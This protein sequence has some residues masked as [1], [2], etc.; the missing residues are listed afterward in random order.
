MNIHRPGAPAAE[1]RD[2]PADDRDQAVGEVDGPLAAVLGCADLDAAAGLALDLAVNDEPA[3]VEIEVPDLD[4]GDLADPEP[5]RAAS[6]TNVW[7]SLSAESRRRLRRG[8]AS[9][10]A[11]Y[12]LR[13][14]RRPGGLKPCALKSRTMVT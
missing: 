7:K 2:V 4:G 5:S 12:R 11:H 14:V 13:P 10:F 1:A 6:T 9:V 8:P 3:V